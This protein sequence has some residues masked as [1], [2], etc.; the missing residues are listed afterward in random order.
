[1]VVFSLLRKQRMRRSFSAERKGSVQG[2]RRMDTNQA[3][4]FE[5][6]ESVSVKFSER[7]A[8][9][10]PRL[11]RFSSTRHRQAIAEPSHPRKARLVPTWRGAGKS[12]SKTSRCPKSSVTLPSEYGKC[13]RRMVTSRPFNS[14][15]ALPNESHMTTAG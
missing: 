5:S 4:I 12:F 1:M 14:L 6:K 2:H 15:A 9:I 3:A 11:R 13:F 8:C 7:P 10:G